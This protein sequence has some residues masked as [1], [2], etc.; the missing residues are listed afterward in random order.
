AVPSDPDRYPTSHRYD[1]EREELHV[2]EG[3]FAPVSA[4]VR[5]F[6]VSGL[7]VIGSWLDYRMQEGAGRR[8]S[9]LDTI[10]PSEWTVEFTE[11]LLRLLWIVE[12]TVAMGPRLDE[13]LTAIVSGRTVRA[14]ELP[15]PT[16]AERE[17][18]G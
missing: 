7:D 1:P 9:Y 12:H 13:L 2:G 11:E 14:A 15:Q 17:A 10:R 3:L 18:P 6:S 16:D 4:D 8:S 5:A